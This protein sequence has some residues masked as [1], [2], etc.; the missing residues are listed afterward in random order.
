MDGSIA[1]SADRVVN[2][3]RFSFFVALVILV[4]AVVLGLETYD[5]IEREAG[6][7]LN[8]INDVCLGIF[9]GE[10]A[11]RFVSYGRRP[12][13][14]FLSGWNVFD[15]IVIGAAFAPGLNNGSTLLRLARVA[16]VIRVVRLL[17][18]VRVLLLA[19]AR[20]IPPMLSLA[21]FASLILYVYA[22]IGWAM[23]GDEDP[24]A[25]GDIGQA[26]LTMF[27][28]LTL[29]NFPD[30]L[31]RG[32]DIEPQSWI[33]FVTFALLASWILLNV[34]IGV[35]INSMEEVREIELERERE[36]LE[37]LRA[38][39]GGEEPLADTQLEQRVVALRVAFE[40]LERELQLV[41]ST[42]PPRPR[43]S[44]AF[45]AKP[46]GRGGG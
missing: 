15:L 40:E 6:G 8:L 34:L 38:E 4:N 39:P 25:W 44:G 3:D 32:M 29:E 31:E 27:V 41:Q 22:M 23:F 37:Q 35:V 46:R 11:M 24:E 12:Q 16:R 7:A 30:K 2:S 28:L 45:G 26:M 36:A 21:V 19:M 1:Q 9:V 20:S 5:S 10:L 42:P 17:P 18:D 33:F 43:G 14:F 13:H